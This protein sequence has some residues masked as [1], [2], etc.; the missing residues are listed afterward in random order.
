MTE[1]LAL[2]VPKGTGDSAKRGRSVRIVPPTVDHGRLDE[3]TRELGRKGVAEARAALAEAN[4]RTN[5]R[6]A[7]RK[8]AR[9]AD[10][11]RANTRNT[12]RQPQRRHA[13]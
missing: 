7:E 5:D 11:A 3:H 13:A 4:R 6:V 2:S 9:T 8:A 1:Q 12:R 10:L